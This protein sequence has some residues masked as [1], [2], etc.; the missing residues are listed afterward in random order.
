M[1]NEESNAD[2]HPSDDEA[3][4]LS[5]E[6]L[7]SNSLD[8]FNSDELVHLEDGLV[9]EPGNETPVMPIHARWLHES[10][11]ADRLSAAHWRKILQCSC[12]NLDLSL[13]VGF[14]EL[15]ICG[16]SFMLH[17]IR[18]M[19]GTAVAVKR[20]LLPRDILE[21]SLNKF[22]R[23]VLPLAPSEVLLLRGNDFKLRRLPG[24]KKRPEMHIL[25]DSLEINK[26]VDKFYENILLPQ[27]SQFLD[28][29]KSPWKEWLENL[30][31]HA[32]IPESQ[33]NEVRN[34]WNE[35]SEE[36]QNRIT[37]RKQLQAESDSIAKADGT[38]VSE[39]KKKQE[40]KGEMK[41]RR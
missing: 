14:V 34:A 30:D 23:I 37:I 28:P 15:S 25:V 36:L 7:I 39:D 29:S 38:F 10:D 13:G 2:G 22:S 21:L 9:G 19:V 41:A 40:T 6:E 11:E 18:K 8:N 32:S 4:S 5:D 1:E 33:L 20:D 31:P 3:D 26:A 35:W 17:Q 27:V 16:E 24:N 12:G